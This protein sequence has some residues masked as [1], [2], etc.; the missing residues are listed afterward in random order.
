MGYV[1]NMHAA[2]KLPY[3]LVNLTLIL[4]HLK[5]YPSYINHTSTTPTQNCVKK[6]K[7]MKIE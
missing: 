5:Y 2:V 3:T 4:T 1:S 6:F 7:Y